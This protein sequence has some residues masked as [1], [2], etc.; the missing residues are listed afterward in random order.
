MGEGSDVMRIDVLPTAEDVAQAAARLYAENIRT[1]PETGMLVATGHTPIRSYQV[2]AEEVAGRAC[3]VS[4]MRAFQLDEY[5]GVTDEDPRSLFGWMRDAFIG[6][7]GLRADQVTRLPVGEPGTD[8]DL[9][10]FDDAI[11]ASGG[12][13]LAVLGLG[14]NGHLGFNEPGSAADSATRRIDLTP[15]SITS[16]AAYWGSEDDVPRSAMTVGMASILASDTVVLLVTGAHKAEILHRAL[17]GP[18]SED[19]PASLLRTHRDYIVICDEASWACP[20][21]GGDVS[22]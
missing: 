3:D 4:R 10:A 9:A 7:L 22:T 11:T 8:A 5:D 20:A 19:V 21:L 2:F 14:P 1:N 16:N 6:P 15:E 12:I 18:I 17:F 13:D